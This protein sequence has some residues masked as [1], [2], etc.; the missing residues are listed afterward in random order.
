MRTKRTVSI[1]SEPCLCAGKASIPTERMHKECIHE[2][3][4]P[5]D[6]VETRTIRKHCEAKQTANGSLAVVSLWLSKCDQSRRSPGLPPRTA[7]RR[8][9][10]KRRETE[11]T[12][13]PQQASRRRAKKSREPKEIVN[14]S[15]VRVDA[16]ER[17]RRCTFE[18]TLGRPD[19]LSRLRIMQA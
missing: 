16:V 2:H 1:P 13:T 14:Q 7:A 19:A 10:D 5:C 3:Y 8:R 12:A 17:E 4:H 11:E 18:G 9:E 6:S 15:R